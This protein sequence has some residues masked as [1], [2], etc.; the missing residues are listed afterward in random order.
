[1]T[2]GRLILRMGVVLLALGA[3]F[4]LALAN[5]PAA[6]AWGAAAAIFIVAIFGADE[7]S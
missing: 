4:R 5:S 3:S 2:T 6:F 1:M 7:A